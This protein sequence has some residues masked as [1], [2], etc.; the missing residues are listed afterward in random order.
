MTTFTPMGTTRFL[1]YI[2]NEK[3]LSN[4]TLVAYENDLAQFQEFCFITFEETNLALVTQMMIRSWVANLVNSKLSAASVKRKISS[5]KAFYKYLMINEEILINPAQRIVLPKIP[6]RLPVFVDQKAME[7]LIDEKMFSDD[8][9]GKRDRLLVTLLYETGIRRDEVINLVKRN[10]NFIQLEIK[11]LGKRNKE[12][13]IPVSKT[14]IERI[15]EL[16]TYARS[17]GFVTDYILTTDKGEKMYPK[18]VY[19]KINHYLGAVTTIN[20][21][22]PHILRHTFATHLLNNGAELNSVKEL[23][24]HASLAATQVYTHNTIEKLK[25]VHKKNHPKS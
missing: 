12:R 21:K 5:L 22:S 16:N 2:K 10:V 19:R 14:M 24:G 15:E 18:F 11:V 6:K 4:N 8:F 7:N 9:A 23:L 3:R 13:I 25:D 20:K 1:S 17:E